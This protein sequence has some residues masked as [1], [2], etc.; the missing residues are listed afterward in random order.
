MKFIYLIVILLFSQENMLF[1]TSKN[2]PSFCRTVVTQHL[3]NS[4]D[5][6][7][8]V[9]TGLFVQTERNK[10]IF[11]YAVNSV[12]H[13]SLLNEVLNKR[14]KIK[15]ILWAGEILVTNGRISE[16]NDIAGIREWAPS[17]FKVQIS[18]QEL[19][20]E[21]SRNPELKRLFCNGQ[22]EYRF[23][24]TG[25]TH[26]D[27]DA[28]VMGDWRHKIKTYLYLIYEAFSNAELKVDLASASHEILDNI[29]KL[30]LKGK[31]DF[32]NRKDADDLIRHLCRINRGWT[33]NGPDLERFKELI[34]RCYQVSKAQY[35]IIIFP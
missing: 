13:E 25:A 26:F 18:G 12:G 10:R 14:W 27:S 1:S 4:F 8:K 17:L 11:I 19:I 9:Y 29:S 21:L 24:S 30:K 7:T 3:I 28:E 23:L 15:G 16:M 31:F 5:Q 20:R 6:Q 2:P 35:E 32:I 33:L 22:V 34:D